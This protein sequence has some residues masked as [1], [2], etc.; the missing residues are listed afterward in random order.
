MKPYNV[1]HPIALISCQT[2]P[3]CAAVNDYLR[4]ESSPRQKFPLTAYLDASEFLASISSG[5]TIILH[6]SSLQVNLPSSRIRRDTH[7]ILVRASHLLTATV[8]PP[9]FQ[10]LRP[11]STTST[12]PI[13]LSQVPYSSC[14]LPPR[15][16]SAAPPPHTAA[17]PSVSPLANNKPKN[18]FP[19]PPQ[20]PLPLFQRSSLSRHPLP[21]SLT[22]FCPYAIQ[23][24]NP[25][26]L[27]QT[28]VRATA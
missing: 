6:V 27:L 17:T 23:V 12:S 1:N 25:P 14:P 4:Q 5:H 22:A 28:T 2:R 10:K 3:Q 24:S 16:P 7:L 19:L 20:P 15:P 13:A 26:S 18:R 21:P 11:S 8:T 9:S